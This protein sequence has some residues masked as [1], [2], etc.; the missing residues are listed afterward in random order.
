M[1]C[2]ISLVSCGGICIFLWWLLACVPVVVL[3]RGA[4]VWHLSPIRQGFFGCHVRRFVNMSVGL[5]AVSPY[6]QY[7]IVTLLSGCKSLN[8]CNVLS[9]P[10]GFSIKKYLGFTSLIIFTVFLTIS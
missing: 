9:I 6:W 4:G 10:T 5:R 8:K 3:L 2:A 7:V 1:A